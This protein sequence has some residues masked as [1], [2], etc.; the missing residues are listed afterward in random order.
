[1]EALSRKRSRAHAAILELS[2][3]DFARSMVNSE[4]S[5]FI[6]QSLPRGV[7][8]I[9]YKSNCFVFRRTDAFVYSIPYLLWIL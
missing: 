1:M 7:K 9:T 4:T 5:E 8:S 2:R 6:H 3:K